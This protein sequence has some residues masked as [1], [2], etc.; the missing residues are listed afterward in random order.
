MNRFF[1]Y[2]SDLIPTPVYFIISPLYHPRRFLRLSKTRLSRFF[3]LFFEDKNKHRR[4]RALIRNRESAI[5]GC[6]NTE[7]NFLVKSL[8]PIDP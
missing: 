3:R 4:A 6:A 1:V 8:T 5:C 2:I 7:W